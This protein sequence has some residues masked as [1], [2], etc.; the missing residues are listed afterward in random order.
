MTGVSHILYIAEFS[1]GGS[2]ESL[3]CLVSGLDRKKFRATVLFYSLPDERTCNRFTNCGA[4]V[5]SLYPRST[6]KSRPQRLHKLNL[7]TK[8]RKIFGAKVERLYESLKSSIYFY[9]FSKAVYKAII[10]E[11]HKIG[12]DLVHLNNGV[13]TDTPGMLAARK[14]RIPAVCHLRTLGRLTHLQVFASRSVSTFI[15]ISKAV[16]DTAVEQG[17]DKMRCIVIP[18]AVDL[19]RFAASDNSSND[20][21]SELGWDESHTVFTLAGRVVAWKGQDYFIRAIA[22]A[23]ESD[24][25]IRGLIVGDSA[26]SE[27]G[28]AYIASLRSLVAEL[29]VDE[30]VKFAGHRNDIPEIM[31]ASDVV[32]CASSSPEPF[33][34]V[35]IE[36]MAAGA[37]VIA[38]DAGG[39]PDIIHDEV[40]GLLV[41]I[42]DS[43]AMAQAF[44]RICMNSEI[45]N[46]MRSAATS[47]VHDRYTVA[48]HVDSICKI[49][50]RLI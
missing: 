40:N 44:L 8:I 1:T 41:P 19:T 3:L 42:M 37:I 16:R 4:T 33:G 17:V 45:N 25:T 18:N 26:D 13:D 10:Q 20:I 28:E 9:R 35:I 2:V 24:K 49:Y 5:H 46:R 39:A 22:E 36:G 31:K 27:S 30:I 34:R 43:H 11:I 15:C 38:T 32:V 48:K 29:A 6:G 7:Q 23:Y 21:R 47:S 14:C 50:E 12:P